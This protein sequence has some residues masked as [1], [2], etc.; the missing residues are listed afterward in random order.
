M[1][2]QFMR[3]A[4]QVAERNLPGS[5]VLIRKA[6]ATLLSSVLVLQPIL[7]HAQSITPEASGSPSYRPNIGAAPN[8]VPLIDIVGPN[9]QGLSHNKYSNFNVGTPGVILNNFDGEVGTS[10]LGG[11]TPGNPNLTGKG[12]ATVILN[13]VT[14]QNRTALNG[15]TEVFGGRADVIIA[16]PN[17]ITC[18]GCGFINTPRATL[19][20]GAPDIGADGSLNGFRVSNGDVTFGRNGANFASGDGSVDLFDVVSRTIQIDGTIYGHDLRLTAGQSKFDY[21]TGEATALDPNAG[22]PEFA[23][24][25]SALGAMQAGRIKMVVTDKGAGVR[26]RGDMAANTGEL[27]LS[28][29]GKISI[30]KASGKGVNV[31]SGQK[32]SVARVTSGKA[33]SLK[34]KNGVAVETIDAD[35]GIL[36]DGGIGFVDATGM[37]SSGSDIE[38]RADGT[39]QL[40]KTAASGPMTF[41]SRAGSISVSDT[42]TSGAA[43]SLSASSGSVSGTNLLSKGDIALLSGLDLGFSGLVRSEG[44]IQATA[45]TG[46]QYGGMEANSSVALSTLAGVISLDKRTAAGSDLRIHQKAIDLSANRA[47][48]AAAGTLFLDADT[49]NL[50]NS[51]MTFGGFDLASTYATNLTGTQLNA[52]VS[53][54]SGTGNVSVSANGISIN[55]ATKL[56]AEKD[57]TVTVPEIQNSGQLAAGGDLRINA[58]GNLTNSATGLIYAGDDA[59]LYVG[60]VLANN[61]G[62]IIARDG[63][64]IAGDSSGTRTAK[65]INRSGLMSADQNLTI[66]T[67]NLINEKVVTPTYNT[68]GTSSTV[69][70][71]YNTYS[72]G[73]YSGSGPF[74]MY[75]GVRFS[76][77]FPSQHLYREVSEDRLTSAGSAQSVIKAGGDL[78]INT[79]DM[80]NSYSSIE[81]GS[82]LQVVGTGT[83][84]N[85]GLQ[86]QRKNSVYCNDP[87]G[88]VYYPDVKVEWTETKSTGDTGGW[89]GSWTYSV[90]RPN[91]YGTR[92]ASKDVG[93]GRTVQSV[94]SIGGVPATIR[95]GGVL[96]IQGFA[97]VNNSAIAGSIADHVAVGAF[98][99]STDPTAVLNNLTAAG[100]L[101]TLGTIPTPQAGGFGGTIPEQSFLYET[102]AAFVDVSKFYGS[103][104]FLNRIGYQPDRKVTFL[105]DAYFENQYIEQQ[106]RLATGSGFTGKDSVSEIKQLL[107]NGASYLGSRP[108]TFGEPLTAEEIAQLTQPIVIYVRQ[109]VNGAEVLAPVLYLAS[110]ADRQSTAAGAV[111][112]GNQVSVDA[113]LF[114]NSGM[115]ASNQNLAVAASSVSSVS[116]TFASGGNMSIRGTD[117]VLLANAKVNA[118]GNLALTSNGD[119]NISAAERTTTTVFGGKRSSTTV[120]RT[121]SLGSEVSA[122]GSVMAQAGGN[123]NVLGS[124]INAGGTV[125]LKA[126]G[127]ITIAEAQNLT[128]IDSVSRKKGGLFGSKKESKSHS[129]TSTTVSSSIMG[130][131][132]ISIE[133]G[134]DTSI[135]ASTLVAGTDKEKADIDVKAGGDIVVASGK[136]TSS[137]NESSSS[138]GLFSKKSSSQQRYD[139]N[140]AASQLYASG[141][142]NLKADEN[143]V[144][145]G[146]GINAG[147]NVGIEGN[148]VALLGAQEQH[149][150]ASS[151]KKSG[152]FAG[153][154]GGFFSLWGK[155]EK[156]KS[157]A[158]ELN[159][160]TRVTG[161][162]DVTLKARDTDVNIIGSSIMTGRD[163]TLEAARDVNVTPGAESSAS[164]EK[165][166]RSG[167]G[168]SFSSGDGSVSI[169]LG[170]GKSLDQ[171]QQSSET[172]AKS[173]LFAG[174]DVSVSAD[175]DANLQA[176]KA[177]AAG[178]VTIDAKN[179]VNLLSAI[180]TTNYE[181]IHQE[182][183]AGISLNLQS[184][185]LGVGQS[186][187][188]AGESMGGENGAY[189]IAPAALAAYRAY[190]A[191]N[192][193]GAAPSLSLTI[194]GTSQKTTQTA[195][196]STPVVTEIQSG[197]ST[198]IK[199]QDGSIAGHG[200]QIAA[201]A[202]LSS[203][204]SGSVLLSAGKDISLEGAKG[205]QS[206]NAHSTSASASIGID[207]T[208]GGPVGNAAYGKTKIGSETTFEVNSHVSG[209][210]A[211]ALNS[212]N[213]TSLKG[214]VVSGNTVIANVG[215][216]LKVESP[217][218]TSTYRE[219]GVSASGGFGAGG[220]SG[221]VSKSNVKGDY[222]NVTEQSGFVAGSD[223]YH[224]SVGGGVDLKGG[225]IA[226]TAEKEK[227]SL[228]ADHLTYS[229]VENTSKASASRVGVNLGPT[230]IPVPV[231]GQPVEEEDHGVARATLTPGNLSLANQTQ[232]LASLNTDLSNANSQVDPLHIARLKAKQQSAAAL[233]ELLNSGIGD[234]SE[235]LGLEE[236]SLAKTSLHTF[237]AA[238]VAAT[239]GGDIGSAALAGALSEIANGALQDVLK[240][241]PSLTPMQKSAITQWVAALVGAVAG[242]QAGAAAALDNVNHNFLT[243][244][245]VE[246]LE[247]ELRSCE[248]SS[249]P[250]SCK[251]AVSTKYSQLDFEQEKQLDACRSRECVENLLGDLKDNPRLAYLDVLKLQELGVNE[252]LAQRLLAYQV[253]ERWVTGDATTFEQRIMDVAAGVGYCED[254]GGSNGC[255]L[256]GQAARYMSSTVQEIAFGALG[257][258]FA[259]AQSVQFRKITT[260][261]GK[262]VLVPDGYRPLSGAGAAGN[263]VGG[264]PAGFARVLDR[265]GN[266][267][268]AD[269]RGNIFDS[270]DALPVPTGQFSGKYN[271]NP[272]HDQVRPGVSPQPTNG[273]TMLSQSVPVGGNSSARIG[274]DKGAREIVVFRKDSESTYHGYAVPAWNELR[275]SEKNALI[276]AGL[277]TSKGRPIE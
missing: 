176:A 137:Y 168:F 207:L 198:S 89:E 234:L 33:A 187:V 229:D 60:G 197:S 153:S 35:E 97:T 39:L 52:V 182:L 107:D 126:A 9:S 130:D 152:L 19:T 83:L 128:T 72:T 98:T 66:M 69:D 253:M 195:S 55:S 20:T 71:A 67:S 147:G 41:L 210:G 27:T 90:P 177:T 122:G 26:M 31:S 260:S 22:G 131:K 216:D 145:S 169:G 2:P 135:S 73:P 262:S 190:K 185:L 270:I 188:A 8:G 189:S 92:D 246:D 32:V 85:N 29:D 214:A 167:F 161:G 116:G 117:S 34:G 273:E 68:V 239:V 11:A 162:T 80:S 44:S 245:Q 259:A 221:G 118:S 261:D 24:D 276:R 219:T 149:A 50:A 134:S 120:V 179:N 223:G 84:T 76:V 49:I 7:L 231:V 112:A 125:G 241:D 48:L 43:L 5:R 79:V 113:G 250:A 184:K 14:S 86:L 59:V 257:L 166:R 40:Q 203:A 180:D 141:N 64:A 88:C 61:E 142:I 94:E 47:D 193:G 170:Y 183:F 274:Y 220:L 114:A 74:V 132:G 109:T 163:L 157:Q 238:F 194:G 150:S 124:D 263:D 227:N 104:Y 233:S 256:A 136:D 17:G 264:L 204:S 37:L 127:D 247:E 159:S 249:D 65:V 28:A 57:L 62:A 46:I 156:E 244:K 228:T 100:A 10:K 96:D 81:A 115:V 58:S 95:S 272:K 99:P 271:S 91:P 6:V 108:R 110:N 18:D 235:K 101:F 173:V 192:N 160:G 3:M 199:A 133:S 158:T 30:G 154:G 225:V 155:N 200:V 240:A 121:T 212:G 123:L 38:I 119:I 178:S 53:G 4:Q 106:H 222:A 268:I 269:S 82:G 129:E 267:V 230:G 237:A 206:F 248:A 191:L 224:V 148:S 215:G 70:A 252:Q 266:I 146:S 218:D 201:G 205:S 243:H 265:D 138:K 21:A 196:N 78:S 211:V 213:D 139:E 56:L 105:G 45:G 251:T 42:V 175:R 208:N 140:T 36:I 226:S 202:G 277:F 111:I 209:T 12:S 174:R 171:T 23:I 143:A 16:N 54:G 151:S 165:Q 254:H 236:G 25:G 172:N 275:Q 77:R 51:A 13:E 258:P 217:Q 15:P 103:S 144:I 1:R 232:D 164:L 87:S 181:H 93:P 63:L 255:F 186:L 75:N 102:R 242:G